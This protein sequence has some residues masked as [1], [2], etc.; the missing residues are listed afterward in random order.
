[1][2]IVIGTLVSRLLKTVWKSTKIVRM[3]QLGLDAKK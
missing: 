2:S 1:M 3:W